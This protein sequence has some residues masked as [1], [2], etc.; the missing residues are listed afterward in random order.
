MQQA[1]YQQPA[2]CTMPDE[3]VIAGLTRK[4]AEIA[5]KVEHTQ[6]VLRQ[7]IIDLD[8]VDAALRLFVPDI[9]LEDIRPSPFPPRNAAFRGEVSRIVFESLRQTPGPLTSHDIAQH[10]MAE[11]GL[12]TSD[13]RLVR[14]VGKRVGACLRHQR[15]RGL[16]RSRPG[17][18]AYLVWEMA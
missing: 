12:N 15:E 4:R 9:E 11:R 3:H 18:G 6:M 17:P 5:G 2:N 10:V 14:L 7:L 1:H 16:V 13:K 8:N